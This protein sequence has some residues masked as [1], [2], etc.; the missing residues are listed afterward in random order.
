M[1]AMSTVMILM[2]AIAWNVGK[3]PCVSCVKITHG[4]PSVPTVKVVASVMDAIN[5]VLDVK[6][7]CVLFAKMK[8]E[9]KIALTDSW[10]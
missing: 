7:H 9:R 4:I 2:V 1:H 5:I 10:D 8:T 3:N 6:K